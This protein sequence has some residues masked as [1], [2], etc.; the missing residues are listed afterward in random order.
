MTPPAKWYLE[1]EGDD[2]I[3]GALSSETAASPVN[4]G[5]LRDIR[6]G[7]SKEKQVLKVHFTI[8]LFCHFAF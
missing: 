8:Y 1:K 3:V 2:M 5:I 6:A 7:T 4:H